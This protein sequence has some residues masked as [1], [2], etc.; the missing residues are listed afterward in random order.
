MPV[1]VHGPQSQEKPIHGHETRYEV[2]PPYI[3]DPLAF[4]SGGVICRW[5]SERIRYEEGVLRTGGCSPPGRARGV[6]GASPETVAPPAAVIINA[7]FQR[8]AIS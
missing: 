5:L 8:T 6:V 2:R 1:F 7:G 4:F 3:H